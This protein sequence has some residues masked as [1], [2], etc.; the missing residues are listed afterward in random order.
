MSTIQERECL[1]CKAKGRPSKWFPRSIGKPRACP[2]C[3]S[4]YWDVAPE[5]GKLT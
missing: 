1:R 2:R 5:Q 3:G 4:P